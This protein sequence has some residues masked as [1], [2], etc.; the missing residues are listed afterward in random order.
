M[1]LPEYKNPKLGKLLSAADLIHAVTQS[2]K[3]FLIKTFS[4]HPSKNIVL[5]LFIRTSSS[6]TLVYQKEAMEMLK[7]KYQLKS[8]KIIL[9]A[10]NKGYF[11]GAIHLLKTCRKLYKKTK[12]FCLVSL[13]NSTSEWEK[14]KMPSDKLFLLDLGYVHQR[15]KELWFKLCDIYAMPSL[16]ESFGLTYLEAWKQGKPVIA[17]DIPPM[18][19]I[20]KGNK[21]GILVPFNSLSSLQQAIEVLFESPQLRK[22]LG[23][24]G[25]KALQSKYS[26]IRLFPKYEKFF[27]F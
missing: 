20:I 6:Q 11:K 2:E 26:F 1:A 19:E 18:K 22:T 8:K 14:A 21:G 4:I 27:F 3:K 13:G 17:A 15:E 24:N 5:P 7:K 9:F 25:L 12:N 23:E 16:S 10:G